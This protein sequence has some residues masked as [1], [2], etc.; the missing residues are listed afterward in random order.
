M[1]IKPTSVYVFFLVLKCLYCSHKQ[2][3]H[4]ILL[5]PANLKLLQLQPKCGREIK[6]WRTACKLLG[7]FA[8]HS[9]WGGSVTKGPTHVVSVALVPS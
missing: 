4:Y 7:R 3:L 2:L 5:V 8:N 9:T 1:I 6:E